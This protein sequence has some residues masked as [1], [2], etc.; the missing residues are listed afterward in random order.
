MLTGIYSLG[1]FLW[2][3]FIIFLLVHFIR[4]SELGTKAQKSTG[5]GKAKIQLSFWILVFHRLSH[6]SIDSEVDFYLTSRSCY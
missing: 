2:E 5:K 3:I 6:N 4:L 1:N